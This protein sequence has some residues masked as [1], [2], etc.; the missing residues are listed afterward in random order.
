MQFA[1]RRASP[2]CNSQQ[3]VDPLAASAARGSCFAP[4]LLLMRKRQPPYLS[5]LPR[6]PL[7]PGSA[8][9]ASGEQFVYAPAQSDITREPL[10]TVPRF[11]ASISL[12]TA[13]RAVASRLSLVSLVSLGESRFS[14]SLWQ[15]CGWQ[16]GLRGPRRR[17]SRPR[18]R[19]CRQYTGRNAP[20][21]GGGARQRPHR[22]RF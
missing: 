4:A 15:G 12:T 20:E 21:W 1:Q 11:A 9:R 22:Q 2:P 17:D 19:P 5:Q 18:D 10:Q 3:I 7:R 8:F 6:G 13:A 16:C 14:S